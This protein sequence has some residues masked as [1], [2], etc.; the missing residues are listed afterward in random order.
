M[1]ILIILFVINAVAHI[2]SYR[3]LKATNAPNTLGVLGFIFINI[4]LALL[5]WQDVSWA[6]WLGLIFPAIGGLGLF[7]STLIKGR[8]TWIDCF[9]L[10]LDI[11]II[12]F[13]LTTYF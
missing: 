4:V 3:K 10:I 5:F 6:K 2:I 1:T 11:L 7:F 12:G 8:G 13:I 9:I